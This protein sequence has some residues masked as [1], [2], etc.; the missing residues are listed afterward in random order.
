MSELVHAL[1]TNDHSLFVACAGPC[2]CEELPRE[3]GAPPFGWLRLQLGVH[4][5]RDFCSG[6]CCERYLHTLNATAGPGERVA[7]GH[8]IFALVDAAMAER[9]A[10]HGT[11]DGREQP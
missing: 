11:S 4:L 8:E 6:T 9:R 3:P 1:H 10:P 7:N 2:E 5:I